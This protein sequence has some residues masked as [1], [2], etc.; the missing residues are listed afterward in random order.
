MS[1]LFK[2]IEKFK[3]KIALVDQHNKKYSYKYISGKIKYIQS[4]IKIR[5]RTHDRQRAA[6]H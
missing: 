3:N 5:I 4:K 1:E 2:N 6:H